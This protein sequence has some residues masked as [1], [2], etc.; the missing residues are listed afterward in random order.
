MLPTTAGT[1]LSLAAARSLDGGRQAEVEQGRVLATR[2][3]TETLMEV[4]ASSTQT[5]G[6]AG[7]PGSPTGTRRGPS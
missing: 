3:S 6:D 2:S 4:K 7:W 1:R 5:E